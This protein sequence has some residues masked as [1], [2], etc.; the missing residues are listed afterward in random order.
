MSSQVAATAAATITSEVTA[1]LT[2]P[3]SRT[4]SSLSRPLM[5]AVPKRL[6]GSRAAG[7]ASL[8][9]CRPVTTAAA[10]APPLPLS[11]QAAATG[12]TR[13]ETASDRPTAA[14]IARAMSPKSWPASPSTKSTGRNTATLVSVLARIA[15]Q[16]SVVPRTAAVRGSSPRLQWTKMF[17]STTTALSISMPTA[18]AMPARL[19]T[20]SVRLKAASARNVPITLTGIDIAT[21][22]VERMFRRNNRSVPSVSSPPTKMLSLTRPI[23]ESM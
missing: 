3:A 16:T 9:S 5:K 4:R 15:P 20:L 2:T 17:S 19:I 22:S 14:A 18:K 13:P 11:S 7:A 21:I 12:T 1:G 8:P 23:A 10:A 6:M